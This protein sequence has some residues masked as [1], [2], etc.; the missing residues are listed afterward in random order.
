MKRIGLLICA[1]LLTA[2]STLAKG[3]RPATKI[4][5]G[6]TTEFTIDYGE[7]KDFAIQLAAGSYYIIWDMKR[8]DEKSGINY[9]RV[10]LLKSNGVMIKDS[11]LFVSDVG[12]AMR[13]GSKF[14]VAKP[15]A[16]RLRVLNQG[17]PIQVWM[18]VMPAKQMKFIPFGFEDGDLK[19]LGIGAKNGKGGAL[20]YNK[21]AYHS[22]KLP[23]G[24]WDVSLYFKR[25][26]GKSGNMV[27]QLERL[28]QYGL[29]QASAWKLFMSQN[30]KE[31]RQEQRLVL[32]KPATVVFQVVNTQD[33]VE[34][35]IGI[36]KAAD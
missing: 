20:E 17:D 16:A 24:K 1:L 19:P 11:L 15:F 21:W 5:L 25:M 14:N 33:P 36:E 23:A 35:V 28:D 22:I 3:T 29:P 2:G 30:G 6:K 7:D 18:T 8:V 12:I 34:Y 13:K 26:D 10:H 9:A 4:A 27:G 31:S 32:T